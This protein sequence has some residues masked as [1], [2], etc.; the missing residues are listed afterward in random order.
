MMN[1]L[2]A[3]KNRRSANLTYARSVRND[4][5]PDLYTRT[6]TA[7]GNTISRTPATGLDFLAD[8]L[9]ED[10]P[11]G[12]SAGAANTTRAPTGT[13]PSVTM[14]RMQPR[15]AD[16]YNEHHILHS[17]YAAFRAR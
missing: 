8:V 10:T 7:T 14:D 13:N 5:S 4:T 11:R 3:T 2:F 12:D 6:M 15:V 17:T 9:R 16:V 1:D